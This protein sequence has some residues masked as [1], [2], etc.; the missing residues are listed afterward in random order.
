MFFFFCYF[1]HYLTLNF[2]SVLHDG[3]PNVGTA[4]VQDAYNQAE[5]TL[6]AC[7]LAVEFLK[8][9]GTFVT[10]VFRSAEYNKLLWVFNQLFKKVTPT[11][12]KSSRTTSAE[13]FVVCEGY[14]APKK[15]DPKLL[16]PKHVLKPIETGTYSKSIFSK[17]ESVNRSGYDD[18]VG[19]ILFKKATV[20]EFIDAEDPV[21]FLGKLNQI[22]FE[23]ESSKYENLEITTYEIKE[24]L[25]DLKVL[26]KRDF[27]NILKWRN[28][29][30]NMIKEELEEEEEEE[31]EKRPLTKE[32]E[33]EMMLEE[34][35]RDVA[36]LERDKKRRKKKKKEEIMK[37]KKRLALSINT[38]EYLETHGEGD[39]ALFNIKT[40]NTKALEEIGMDA[41][42]EEEE[43]EDEQD[44]EEEEDEGY[45]SPDEEARRYHEEMEEYFD[46]MYLQY[47]KT[48]KK[49]KKKALS[50][51]N[52]ENEEDETLFKASFDQDSDDDDDENNL[53]VVP[54]KDQ[55]IE[56]K[57]WFDQ[58]EFKALVDED[59][60]EEVE[61]KKR[62]ALM[63]QN[64]KQKTKEN[65]E[66]EGEIKQN[67]SINKKGVE[68][69]D[70]DDDEMPALEKV[71]FDDG[72]KKKK[73]KRDRR[74][75]KE[76]EKKKEK[77]S[78]EIVKQE[79]F[80]GD[81]S[82][83][84][85]SIEDEEKAEILALAKKMIKNDSRSEI[86]DSMLNKRFFGD[87]EDLP[88]WFVDEERAFNY[89]N[90]PITKE[91]VL[92]M[93]A[94]LRAINALEPKKVAEAKARKR[95]R[96][97]QALEKAKAKAAKIM[98]S[99]EIADGSKLREIEKIYRKARAK[100]KQKKKY[101]VS[102]KHNASKVG[103]VKAKGNTK[104]KY[105]DAR[106]KKDKRA[107]QRKKKRKRR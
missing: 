70:D 73:K 25:K 86:A 43:E 46:R 100:E 8:T 7:K 41:I 87:T 56:T 10:K 97:Q 107:E 47:L 37:Q 12:P 101:V 51:L 83:E 11:K 93:K 49:E 28:K 40:I 15:I 63:H 44:M 14:I 65:E 78:F 61:I 90:P 79:K 106:M 55:R 67:G 88:R 74:G 82:E 48:K 53:V 50:K 77:D 9:N 96:L 71:E 104:I 60:D 33:E 62:M 4:W 80:E 26:N 59:E 76:E 54:K 81:D 95:K 21:E 102:R 68:E 27:A 69:E 52:E 13:I 35:E 3:A 6:A 72:K 42:E 16:D 58:D 22:T 2:E 91:E 66:K 94:K 34:L 1:Y 24:C 98:E 92:E 5:L 31:E 103:R 64:K 85:E 38:D 36:E 32:E 105:V 20:Q 89:Y 99:D 23:G 19:A 17:K 45:I 84:E 18:D 29:I 75:N 39:D 57:M 30:K